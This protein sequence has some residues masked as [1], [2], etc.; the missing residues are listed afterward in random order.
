MIAGLMA[1]WN[2][3]DIVA[4]VDDDFAAWW[5]SAVAGATVEDPL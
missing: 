2:D 1:T 3:E 5:A 4:S